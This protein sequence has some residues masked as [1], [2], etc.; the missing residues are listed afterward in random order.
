MPGIHRSVTTASGGL[1]ERHLG[2]VGRVG[3]LL[4]LVPLVAKANAEKRT[5]ARAVVDQENPRHCHLD[6]APA[7]QPTKQRSTYA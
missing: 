2:G 7:P 5:R 3:D 6:Y 4:D 1:H